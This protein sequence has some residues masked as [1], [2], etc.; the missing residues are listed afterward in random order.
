MIKPETERR[1]LRVT[2]T[3]Q[4][5][6]FRP[7]VFNLATALSLRGVVRNDSSGVLVDVEGEREWIDDFLDR[8]RT[9]PRRLAESESI[10]A[11]TEW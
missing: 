1:R 3:V 11:E 5:V 2:G 7:F 8:I 10:A 9:D 4:G 6:G